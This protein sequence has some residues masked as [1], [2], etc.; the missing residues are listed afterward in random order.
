M[1][2]T[3]CC[4]KLNSWRNHDNHNPWNSWLGEDILNLQSIWFSWQSKDPEF[5]YEIANIV[6]SCCPKHLRS[7]AYIW[8]HITF[9]YSHPHQHLHNNNIFSAYNHINQQ[10]QKCNSQPSSPSLPPSQPS[11][12]SPSP[13]VSLPSSPF[14]KENITNQNLQCSKSQDCCW[15]GSD[16]GLNGCESQHNRVIGA[17]GLGPCD[18]PEYVADWANVRGWIGCRLLLY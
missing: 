3:K 7:F 5:V 4:L 16:A 15:G 18:K 8:K 17:I 9:K 11:P 14:P 6:S 10:P 13:F 12:H 1:L 2:L